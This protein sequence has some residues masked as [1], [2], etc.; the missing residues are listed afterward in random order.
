MRFYQ[1]SVYGGC[2]NALFIPGQSNRNNSG[3]RSA[4]LV[5]ICTKL[6]ELASEK[7]AGGIA[8]TKRCGG[9]RTGVGANQQRNKEDDGGKDMHSQQESSGIVGQLRK[10]VGQAED[11]RGDGGGN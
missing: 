1:R 8:P 6:V 3:A 11:V 10:H 9:R 7:D 4:G 2:V 5:A